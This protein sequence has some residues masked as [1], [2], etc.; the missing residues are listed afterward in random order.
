[1]K[2]SGSSS[3]RSGLLLALIAVLGVALLAGIHQLTRER[4]AEQERRVV[5]Q[6]LAEVLP[7]SAFN[8]DLLNDTISI[9]DPAML[10]QPGPATVYRARLDGNPAAIIVRMTAVEGYNGD[11]V[12]LV[13]I[14]SDGSVSG[15]RVVAHRETPG[16]GDPIERA[17]SDW[18]DSFRD[19]SLGNP[20][21]AQWAVRRDGGEFDQF[22]GATI[23]PRAV[24]G[25]VRRALEF[26]QAHAR[27]LFAA[28]AGA[29][30]DATALRGDEP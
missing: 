7:R 24:V 22:T 9:T 11:I 25:A 15:V 17:R 5:L 14:R 20:P 6:R 2:G 21:P 8:N 13:G 3:L 30:L 18:V 19:R 10:K 27:Q 4:I 29:A 12:L 23:T 16:L 26:H 1:M 28:P